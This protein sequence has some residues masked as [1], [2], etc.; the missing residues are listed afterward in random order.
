MEYIENN[1]I[2]GVPT[3]GPYYLFIYFSNAHPLTYKIN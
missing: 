1:A 2:A 3:P